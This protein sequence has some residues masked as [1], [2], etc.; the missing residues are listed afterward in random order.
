VVLPELENK[1][2]GSQ[3]FSYFIILIKTIN[4][5][6]KRAGK[7]IFLQNPTPVSPPVSAIILTFFIF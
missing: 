4:I 5:I 1:I 6:K 7:T 2:K 3:D